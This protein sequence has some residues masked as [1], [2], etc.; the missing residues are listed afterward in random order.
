LQNGRKTE[1]KSRSFSF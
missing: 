1:I